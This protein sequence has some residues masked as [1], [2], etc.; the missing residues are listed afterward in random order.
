MTSTKIFFVWKIVF[1]VNVKRNFFC[2][3][4]L[5]ILEKSKRFFRF[6]FGQKLFFSF[7][8]AWVFSPVKIG[9]YLGK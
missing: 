9:F 6:V 5:I 4:H 3:E 8:S 7:K 1:S 2:F